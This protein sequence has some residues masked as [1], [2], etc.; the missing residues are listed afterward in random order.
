MPALLVRSLEWQYL[1]ASLII[2]QYRA[3]KLS[4]NDV[5]TSSKQFI[6][7]ET[8]RRSTDGAYIHRRE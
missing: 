3:S 6:G 7:K 8:H 2:V 1:I 5:L 4:P